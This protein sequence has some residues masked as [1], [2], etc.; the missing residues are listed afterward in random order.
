[1]ESKDE[2][3]LGATSGGQLIHRDGILVS[4]LR[5]TLNPVTPKG[6]SNSGM[7]WTADTEM[8]GNK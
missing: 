1:M 7:K 2:I 8:W 5:V 4:T 3:S 6:I